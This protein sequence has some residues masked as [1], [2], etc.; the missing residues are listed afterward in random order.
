MSSHH[1]RKAINLH[2]D[3]IAAG[4]ARRLQRQAERLQGFLSRR[5]Q[6]RAEYNLTLLCSFLCF[7]YMTLAMPFI[8]RQVISFWA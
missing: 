1:S 3:Q 5:G 6:L 8:L 2:Y 7:S 4:R